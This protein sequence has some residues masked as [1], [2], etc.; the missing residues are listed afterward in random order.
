MSLVCQHITAAL[1][2]RQLQI[3]TRDS[4]PRI[5]DRRKYFRILHKEIYFR[6]YSDEDIL[7][8]YTQI[9]YTDGDIHALE[10]IQTEID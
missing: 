4:R 1:Y 5:L 10:Y 3:R 8:I 9:P 6:K 2:C 7:K